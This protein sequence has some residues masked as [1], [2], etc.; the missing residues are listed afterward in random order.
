MLMGTAISL[1]VT[2]PADR[3][4][5]S[6]RLAR[7][8]QLHR[9]VPR[10]AHF[11][12]RA[13]A[14]DRQPEDAFTSN[15]AR[16]RAHHSR[17][18]RTRSGARRQLARPDAGRCLRCQYRQA[19]RRATPGRLPRPTTR[20]LPAAQPVPR[21]CRPQIRL[22]YNPGRARRSSMGR[23]SSCWASR[24]FR[25]CWPRSPW[26]RRAS[27]KPFCRSMSRAFRRMN[28]CS[29]RF[30]PSWSSRFAEWLLLADAA[31]HLLRAASSPAIPRRSSWRPF[32][33][34]SAWR[35][36]AR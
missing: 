8:A 29:A 10:I 32:S 33:T 2:R 26:R 7:V 31:V 14:V 24:C 13:V 36:S 22:W 18:L 16:G 21:R 34:R 17:A 12:R 30:S 28:S 3:R 4:A 35:R 11:P 19:D 23:A 9:R 6:R 1:T 27:R 15:D 20:E 25:R 5:G